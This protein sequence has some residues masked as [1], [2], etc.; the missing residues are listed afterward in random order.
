MYWELLEF[1]RVSSAGSEIHDQVPRLHPAILGFASSENT[2][3]MHA[4]ALDAEFRLVV[5]LRYDD[6]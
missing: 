1:L 2:E 4:H 3:N 5:S 6:D